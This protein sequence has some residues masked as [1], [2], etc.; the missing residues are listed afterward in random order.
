MTFRFKNGLSNAGQKST[1]FFDRC[2]LPDFQTNTGDTAVEAV[3]VPLCVMRQICDALRS[4]LDMFKEFPYL[5]PSQQ[6][7]LTR[8]Y[9]N[10]LDNWLERGFCKTFKRR[11]ILEACE[12]MSGGTLGGPRARQSRAG[13]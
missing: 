9:L 8:D 7:L 1:V 13:E 6:R 5:K 11:V 10:K 12:R 3:V 2:V 4:D